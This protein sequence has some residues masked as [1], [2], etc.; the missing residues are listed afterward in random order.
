[1]KK[2]NKLLIVVFILLD[3][4]YTIYSG[5]YGNI[6]NIL[7]NISIFPLVFVPTLIRKIFKIN[8]PDTFETLFLIF[9][10][11]AQFL[12]SIL[13]FYSKI[14]C[15]DSIL[16]FI[17]GIITSLIGIALLVWFHK[18]NKK[19]ITF[20]VLFIT[21]TAIAI[22]GLWEYFEFIADIFTKGDAQKVAETGVTDTMKDMIVATL[23]SILFSLF[24]AYEETR[25]KSWLIQRFIKDVK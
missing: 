25:G 11:M 15:W 13:G 16:H 3:I 19:N 7:I 23:G 9:L 22:A 8:F 4:G 5:L 2:I 24:Y 20:N 1:M 12:G 14:P 10:F 21:I 6:K 17:S 18:Y